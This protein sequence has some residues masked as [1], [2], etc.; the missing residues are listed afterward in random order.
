MIRT[1]ESCQAVY[2]DAERYTYCPHDRFMSAED[3]EQKK[4]GIALIGKQIHFAHQ[5]GGPLYRVRSV[6]WNGMVTIDNMV[7]EF[8]PHLFVVSKEKA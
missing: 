3:L 7:G 5:P 6:G 1:C 4:A 2:D 8:A